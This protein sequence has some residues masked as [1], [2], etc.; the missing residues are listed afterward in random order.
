MSGLTF[1]EGTHSY[2]FDGEPVPGVTSIL[3]PISDFS[4]VDHDV[5]AAASAFGTAVH[6]ACELD[7]LGQLDEETLDDALAPYLAGWRRFC[8][9]HAAAWERIEDKVYHQTL[10][11]AGTLDRYGKLQGKP[12]VV[13]IK[14]ST[15][16]MP[17][18]GPQLAAYKNAIP[19][20]LPLTGRMAVQLKGDGTYVAKSYTDR[21]DWPLFCSL[22]TLRQWCAQHSITPN[23][24]EKRYV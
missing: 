10:R 12:W 5:L 21:S 16:L 1:D 14:T 24:Q 8:A 23:F 2:R 6:R 3:K 9:D 15:T 19:G 13:D 17:S 11:Y 22:L 20:V 4:F 18:V 7:D